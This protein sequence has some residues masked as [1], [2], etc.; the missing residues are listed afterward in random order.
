MKEVF[1]VE[2]REPRSVLLAECCQTSRRRA[3]GTVIKALLEKADLVAGRRLTRSSSGQ[4]L[5]A[6]V[7]R[8]RPARRCGR[9]GFPIRL[10]P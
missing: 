5:P 7:G 2:A 10:T 1:V 6:A 4:V 9:P 8:L 3:G